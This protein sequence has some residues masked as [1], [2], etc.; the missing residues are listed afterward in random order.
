MK[1]KRQPTMKTLLLLPTVM[2]IQC[3]ATPAIVKLNYVASASDLSDAWW[4]FCGGYLFWSA[5][6]LAIA[7]FCRSPI[8]A[9]L[10]GLEFSLLWLCAYF[11]QTNYARYSSGAV[12]DYVLCGPFGAISHRSYSG[13]LKSIPEILIYSAVLVMY[14]ITCFLFSKSCRL[15]EQPARISTNDTPKRD[16]FQFSLRMIELGLVVSIP[17]I[18]VG[19]SLNWI[20]QRHAALSELQAIDASAIANYGTSWPEAPNGLRLFGERGLWYVQCREDTPQE[21]AQKMQY[22]FPEAM[23]LVEERGRLSRFK[24]K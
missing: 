20:R 18:W 2:A 16:Q 5:I 4:V 24:W 12:V 10:L 17:L 15:R 14:V 19:Y 3:A 22:L 11:Y 1:T 8:R 23:V 21:F 13:E 9:G 6:P 7:L